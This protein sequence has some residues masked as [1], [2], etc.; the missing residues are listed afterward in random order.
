[1][2]QQPTL[3][4]MY[5]MSLVYWQYVSGGR[6][7][8]LCAT[9]GCRQSI[10]A[11]CSADCHKQTHTASPMAV[12]FTAYVRSHLLGSRVRIPLRAWICFCCAR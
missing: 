1:M 2:L 9:C 7:R 10:I 8:L 11:S 3:L 12:R 4:T 6:Q 5:F